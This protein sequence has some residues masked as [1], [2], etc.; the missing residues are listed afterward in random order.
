MAVLGGI[1]APVVPPSA[2]CSAGRGASAPA[3]PPAA[4]PGWMAGVA[5]APVTVLQPRHSA[6]HAV[7]GDGGVATDKDMLSRAMK[8]KAALNDTTVQG[9]K[10]PSKSFL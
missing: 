10:F 2:Q 6:R 5:P 9:T 4:V 3:P 1:L 8:R 7:A